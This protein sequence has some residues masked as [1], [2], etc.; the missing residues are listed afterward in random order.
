MPDAK[1]KERKG[2][3]LNESSKIGNVSNCLQIYSAY[4]FANLG[5]LVSVKLAM[6]PENSA[7]SN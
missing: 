7:T 3:E 2:F 1:A 6:V 5:V 4:D